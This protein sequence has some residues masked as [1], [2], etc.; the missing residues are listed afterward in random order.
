[1]ATVRSLFRQNG[2]AETPLEAEGEA[3][4]QIS[5]KSFLEWIGPTIFLGVAALSQSPNILS[6]AL[7]VISNYLTD[8][9]KGL[10]VAPKV[11]LDIVVEKKKGVCKRIHYCGPEAGLNG[12]PATVRALMSG[13]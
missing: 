10:A 1:M 9:F 12:L 4:L 7:G 6:L 2:I 5:E 3:F 13:D 11:K 8:L